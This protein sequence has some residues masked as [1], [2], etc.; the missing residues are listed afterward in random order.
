MIAGQTRSGTSAGKVP[1]GRLGRRATTPSGWKLIKGQS[2][3]DAEEEK[4]P[5]SKPSNDPSGL[6][7][8][9]TD[10][11]EKNNLAAQNPEK[12]QE[13]KTRMEK[14]LKD[15]VP[16]GESKGNKTSRVPK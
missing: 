11:G 13:M 7:N 5:Q 9:A 3:H 2:D 15:A 10:I 14:L 1:V 6:Y 12:L 8:L 16:S 4:N